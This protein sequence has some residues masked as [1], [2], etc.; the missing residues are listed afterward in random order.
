MRFDM[1][2]PVQGPF[3]SAS[4]MRLHFCRSVMSCLVGDLFGGALRVCL[5]MCRPLGASRLV[6]GSF[7]ST[8]RG[9][10][11]EGTAATW[12]MQSQSV[13]AP[14][15]H[16]YFMLSTY[17]THFL[18]WFFIK[19]ASAHSSPKVSTLSSGISYGCAPFRA[20]P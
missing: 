10:H 2:C 13:V 19:S 15:T 6:A 4:P 12:E 14:V 1:S 11:R 7:N 20:L 9:V 5:S 3:E 17:T 18:L 16:S 8:L